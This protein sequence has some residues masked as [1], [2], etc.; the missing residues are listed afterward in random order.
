MVVVVDARGLLVGLPGRP[1]ARLHVPVSAGLVAVPAVHD[2]AG[3]SRVARHSDQRVVELV[4]QL[5]LADPEPVDLVQLAVDLGPV[6]LG[7][8][9][10]DLAPE[11]LGDLDAQDHG[12]LALVDHAP[13]LERIGHD[14]EPALPGTAALGVDVVLQLVDAL[15]LKAHAVHLVA[16]VL[17]QGVELAEH[18]VLHEEVHVDAQAAHPCPLEPPVVGLL[19]GQRL[20]VRPVLERRPAHRVVGGPRGTRGDGALERARHRVVVGA[21]H[22]RVLRAVA[23]PGPAAVRAPAQELEGHHVHVEVDHAP[24]PA[25][26]RRAPAGRAGRADLHLGIGRAALGGLEGE[27]R[28]VARARRRE[29]QATIPAHG[30]EH[31]VARRGQ[32]DREPATRRHV[33]APVGRL[34]G[35]G[36]GLDAVVG[37]AD[38]AGRAR[39]EV[40]RAAVEEVAPEL[41]G[42]HAEHLG[43]GG[44]RRRGEVAAVLGAAGHEAS[45]RLGLERVAAVDEVV[46]SALGR[47][48]RRVRAGRRGGGGESEHAEGGHRPAPCRSPPFAHRGQP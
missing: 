25:V 14:P 37:R 32:G 13:G 1:G 42:L 35:A 41:G 43:P 18:L 19:V 16:G 12:Q 22:Q 15:V 8:V 21:V 5:H 3:A 26:G 28:G 10:V 24:G 36:L 45:Q 4:H 31:L 48:L 39:H 30:G 27:H 7:L 6:A 17:L 34:V 11:G 9:V 23:V 33:H 20:V 40:A 2:R 46:A 29:H 47:R 38:Q 44:V